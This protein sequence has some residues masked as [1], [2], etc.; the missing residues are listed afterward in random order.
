MPLLFPQ[1]FVAGSEGSKIIEDDLPVEPGKPWH[2]IVQFQRG[3]GDLPR[4]PVNVHTGQNR[5]RTWKPAL[6]LS[7]LV[8]GRPRTVY[9]FFTQNC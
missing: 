2:K 7:S 1:V 6:R 5:G 8:V 4:S 9:N 3:R